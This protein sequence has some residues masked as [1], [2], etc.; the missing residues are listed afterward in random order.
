MC[1]LTDCEGLEEIDL[2]QS[3]VRKKQGIPFRKNG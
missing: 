2:Y 3:V 1:G